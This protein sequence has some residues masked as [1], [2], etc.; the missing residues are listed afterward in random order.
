MTCKKLKDGKWGRE[1]CLSQ[2]SVANIL[3][4]AKCSHGQKIQHIKHWSIW[5]S[6]ATM[7]NFAAAKQQKR[8][9]RAGHDCGAVTCASPDCTLKYN[10][11]K[12]CCG[13]FIYYLCP[14]PDASR[15]P[16]PAPGSV[17]P[18]TP[19][20]GQRMMHRGN[21][22]GAA[23][24]G[25]QCLTHRSFGDCKLPTQPVSP[26]PLHC[27]LVGSTLLY[28][29]R[30]VHHQRFTPLCLAGDRGYVYVYVRQ[31]CTMQSQ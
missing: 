14:S 7:W 16:P 25:S 12:T 10:F 15:S 3:Q 23:E 26:W 19:L 20:E 18:A 21:T 27:E 31:R 1:D 11:K 28:G 9:F 4:A 17:S 29:E 6:I 2:T 24:A 13:L 30:G 5:Y 8:D 22:V